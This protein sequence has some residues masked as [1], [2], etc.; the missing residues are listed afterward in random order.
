M[1]QVALGRAVG[2]L[3]VAWLREIVQKILVEPVRD[4]QYLAPSLIGCDGYC[5]LFALS[6]GGSWKSYGFSRAKESLAG[7]LPF[8][9]SQV[10]VLNCWPL[11]HA[12]VKPPPFAFSVKSGSIHVNVFPLSRAASALRDLT[13]VNVCRLTASPATFL[14]LVPDSCVEP[15]S[16]LLRKLCSLKGSWEPTAEPATP[17]PSVSP[18]DAGGRY[19]GGNGLRQSTRSGGS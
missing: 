17:P 7:M 15:L 13:Q 18:P 3:S 11:F 2:R 1:T 9:L 8:R 14:L 12:W 19:R 6:I 5:R 4:W 16:G 10:G